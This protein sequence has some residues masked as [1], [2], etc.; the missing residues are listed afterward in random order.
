MATTTVP[1]TQTPNGMKP[2]YHC[3]HSVHAPIRGETVS[4]TIAISLMRVARD[5]PTAPFMTHPTVLPTLVDPNLVYLLACVSALPVLERVDP[6]KKPEAMDP[7][8]MA[9]SACGPTR[10]P[11]MRGLIDTYRQGRIIS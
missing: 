4:E 6:S 7:T 2:K 9:T 8:S 5:V 3:P 10:I 11:T 1:T